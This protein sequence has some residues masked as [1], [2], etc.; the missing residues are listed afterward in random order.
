MR[1]LEPL[2]SAVAMRDIEPVRTMVS[3]RMSLRDADVSGFLV[4]VPVRQAVGCQLF[5]ALPARIL[6]F[7]LPFRR[8]NVA[9]ASSRIAGAVFRCMAVPQRFPRGEGCCIEI[10]E[11]RHD[12]N[13]SWG[14][15]PGFAA[16]QR[17]F[18][19]WI[20]ATA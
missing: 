7:F 11:N 4:N 5:R 3:S 8:K 20:V 10:E 6:T 14:N 18:R 15:G 12:R 9:P 13:D 19:C 1:S 16:M 2:K 17:K